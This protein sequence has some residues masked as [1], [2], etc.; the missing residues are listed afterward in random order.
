MLS[1]GL[2][3]SI[4]MLSS[5]MPPDHGPWCRGRCR[6][7]FLA[8][9]TAYDAALN[10]QDLLLSLASFVSLGPI[11]AARSLIPALR[12]CLDGHGWNEINLQKQVDSATRTS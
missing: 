2:L 4:L 11:L 8:D 1:I 9:L 12:T 5:G 3:V 7:K 6:Y 10:G